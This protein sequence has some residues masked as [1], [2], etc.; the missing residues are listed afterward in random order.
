MLLFPLQAG[1]D[2]G[3]EVDAE[4]HFALREA[5]P[6]VEWLAGAELDEIAGRAGRLGA[7]PRNLPVGIFEMGEVERVGDPLFGAFYR[8]AAMTDASYA[9]LPIS[10]QT[11]TDANGRARTSLNAALLDPRSG[12]VLWQGI[13]EGEPGEP[14]SPVVVASMAE[15]VA[16]RLLR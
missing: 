15:R 14:G 12:R 5:G 10:A 6:S 16:G 11:R 2:A 1:A 3:S 13:V 4:L 7:D 9:L 8:L